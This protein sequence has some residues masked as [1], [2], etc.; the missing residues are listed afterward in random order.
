MR[1]VRC[2][3]CDKLLLKLEYGQGEAKCK[4]GA[5]VLFKLVS[6]KSLEDE[7]YI[8]PLDSITAIPA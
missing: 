8:S 3:K 6:Q 1:E 5:L 7:I 4:C 2:H